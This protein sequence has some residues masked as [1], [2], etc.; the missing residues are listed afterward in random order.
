MPSAGTVLTISLTDSLSFPVSKSAEMIPSAAN[1]IRIGDIEIQEV[2]HHIRSH[3]LPFCLLISATAGLCFTFASLFEN[4]RGD[5][6][7]TSDQPQLWHRCCL[8]ET[9][10]MSDLERVSR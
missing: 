1:L 8:Y 3:E 6:S 7:K 9:P 4:T 2:S 10:K 5:S